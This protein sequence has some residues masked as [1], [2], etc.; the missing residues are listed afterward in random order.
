[1]NLEKYVNEFKNGNQKAF[2]I[3]YKGSFPFVRLAIYK[4]V[5]N[6]DVVEDLIQDVYTKLANNISTYN[7]N[8]FKNYIYTMAKNI[9]IDYVRKRKEALLDNVEIIPDK[10]THPYL[11]YVINHLDDALK[12]VFLMKVLYGHTTKK[13]SQILN[14]KPSEI[15]QMYYQAKQILKKNLKEVPDEA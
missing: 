7:S 13:I 3:I 9:A 1:M 10:S 12:E 11:A 2:D 5:Q 6:K 8:N 4:Y 15:N 14:K